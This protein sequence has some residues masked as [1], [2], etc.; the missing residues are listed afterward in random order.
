MRF[1]VAT[2]P[3]HDAVIVTFVGAATAPAVMVKVCIYPPAGTV[4]RA[5]TA[6]AAGLELESW[7]AAPPLAAVPLRTTALPGLTAPAAIEEE[8]RFTP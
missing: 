7:T 6:A 3:D 5:G 8:A 2:P 1:A 4:T